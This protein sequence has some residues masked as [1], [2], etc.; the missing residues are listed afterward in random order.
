MR[1]ST[2]VAATILT[3]GPALAD[4]SLERGIDWQ[5]VETELVRRM[6]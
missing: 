1:V 4:C 6:G 3:A 5:E 2:F